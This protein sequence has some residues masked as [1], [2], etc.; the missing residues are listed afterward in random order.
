MAENALIIHWL[1]LFKKIEVACLA[2]TVLV[3]WYFFFRFVFVF[4]TFIWFT[5]LI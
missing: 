5:A 4:N 2:E 1:E 3:L